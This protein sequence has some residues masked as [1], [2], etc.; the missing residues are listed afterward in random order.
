MRLKKNKFPK[1]QRRIND[2]NKIKHT[3]MRLN[4]RSLTIDH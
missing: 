1:K 3:L 2:S 4:G